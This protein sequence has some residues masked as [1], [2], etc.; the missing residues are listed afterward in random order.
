MRDGLKD[1]EIHVNL[2]EGADTYTELFGVTDEEFERVINQFKPGAV[3]SDD[4]ISNE[5]LILG[6]E[7]ALAKVIMHLG[8][9]SQF[10]IQL[11]MVIIGHTIGLE[12]T[13]TSKLTEYLINSCQN[14]E[15]L[16]ELSTKMSQTEIVTKA[17][18][19]IS[20]MLEELMGQ[21]K[22][23]MRNESK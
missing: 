4:D 5:D 8:E 12:L 1:I 17:K 15:N 23:G 21:L 13:S 7:I 11:L 22:E 19:E 18:S 6:S 10:G 20:T 3:D 14:G 9:E 16:V 2:K